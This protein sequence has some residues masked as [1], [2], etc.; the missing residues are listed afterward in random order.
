[1]LKRFYL[2]NRV[3]IICLAIVPLFAWFIFYTIEDRARP[4]LDLPIS[5]SSAGRV[6]SD[7]NIKYSG[8]YKLEFVFEREGH[9]VEE[10][11]R[12]IGTTF[13]IGRNKYLDDEQN[14]PWRERYLKNIE[15]YKNKMTG[16]PV[17]VKWQLSS[18]KSDEMICQGESETAGIHYSHPKEVFR[19]VP[20][21]CS[22]LRYGIVYAGK[23]HFSAEVVRNTPELSGYKT[24]IRLSPSLAPD[25]FFISSGIGYLLILAEIILLLVLV[26]KGYKYIKSQST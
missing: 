18:A 21:F 8:Q 4:V 20:Y 16:V 19:G 13:F 7:I 5:L 6:E 2:Q 25:E 12:D 24:C 10:I 9:S 14:Y 1:M 22:M 17:T 11:R 3:L 15:E 23:Y 26:F